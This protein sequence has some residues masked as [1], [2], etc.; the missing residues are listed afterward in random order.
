MSC[1]SLSGARVSGPV[2][3]AL[4]QAF[5]LLV[6]IVPVI[7][8]L[9]RSAR[10][11]RASAAAL[12]G[13]GP[14]PAYFMAR[15]VLGGLL[16]AALTVVAARPYVAYEKSAS[17]VF[18][19]DVSR[20]MQ[21]R[22]SCSEPTF[23]ERARRVIRDTVDALP[24]ASVG[25]FAFDRFAFPVTQQTTDHAYIADVIEHG[26]YVGL[27]LEATQTEIANA[28][29]VV[30]AKKRRLPEIYGDVTHAILLSDGHVSGDFRRRLQEPFAQLADAG[31]KVSTVGIGNPEATPI[32]DTVSGQCVNQLVEVS[33]DTVKIPLRADILKLIATE[34]GGSYYTETETGRLVEEL[35]AELTRG[36]VADAGSGGPRRDVSNIFLAI[37]TLALLGFVYMP[38]RFAKT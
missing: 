27:M 30:A 36:S 7:L 18:V 10:L 3:F 24:E 8:V 2:Q 12:Q 28:L 20:S 16:M 5:L 32:A 34:T 33:G 15:M 14:E 31:I 9:R 6:L 29:S 37:A 25:I 21:A 23:L 13:Q 17:F 38:V 26:L 4:P 19:V 11:A 35:R 1:T 22:Y